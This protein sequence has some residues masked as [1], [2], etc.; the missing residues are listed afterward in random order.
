[1]GGWLATP[2][3]GIIDDIVVHQ[4]SGLEHFD[5]TGQIKHRIHVSFQHFPRCERTERIQR[6]QR[7]QPL[8][9]LA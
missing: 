1:M 6:Q 2:K 3:V 7:A 4:R 8:A 9:A 5:S